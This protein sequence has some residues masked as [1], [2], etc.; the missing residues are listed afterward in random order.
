MENDKMI[1]QIP[2]IF[3][4]DYHNV[5]ELNKG[6]Y[7]YCLDDGYIIQNKIASKDISMNRQDSIHIRLFGKD[8]R[9]V[10]TINGK[11]AEIPFAQNDITVHFSDFDFRTGK[12][13]QFRLI[14]GTPNW[15]TIDNISQFELNNLRSGKYQFEIQRDD[16]AYGSVEFMILPPW[17]MSYLAILFYFIAG[18]TGLY[19][20]N[21]YY[22]KK[23][24]LTK[25]KMMADQA[26]L[27]KEHGMEI[28]NQRLLNENL[29]K[30]KELA[31][32]TMHLIQ[33]NEILH[34]IK[35]ELMQ[36]KSQDQKHA[37]RDIQIILKQ[38]NQNLTLEADKKLFDTS[39]DKVHE[40][41]LKQLKKDFPSLTREDLKLAAFL[42]MD[43][44]SKEIAPLFNISLRGLENKRY[45][46]RKKLMLG[47][48][49][50]LTDYFNEVIK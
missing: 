48:E 39:F 12:T 41:F 38:I 13:Y 9:C 14:P 2:Y 21:R 24:K 35:E 47:S 18:G 43:L 30:N 22:N 17:Y 26:R 36:L 42:R 31:N 23:F 28:E 16:G 5:I 1:E 46:L 32:V 27:I 11:R 25:D 20:V 29:Y 15:K 33:K 44:S 8:D 49:V 50:D 6:Q 45:R 10:A 40:A 37:S 4:R 19:A 3:N 7:A 34:D